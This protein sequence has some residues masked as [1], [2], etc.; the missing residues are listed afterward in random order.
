MK[1]NDDPSATEETE[2]SP[3]EESESDER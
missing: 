1:S 3:D 2:R